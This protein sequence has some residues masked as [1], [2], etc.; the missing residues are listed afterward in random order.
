MAWL[1]VN[2]DQLGSMW[3]LAGSGWIKPRMIQSKVNIRWF[4]LTM[5]RANMAQG[6][7]KLARLSFNL[8]KLDSDSIQHRPRLTRPNLGLG[9]LNSLRLVWTW[10]N[11]DLGWLGPTLSRLAQPNLDS[12]WFN[13]K[14][15][16]LIKA[17]ADLV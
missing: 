1:E 17:H 3:T 2:P 12:K 14:W 8:A 11:V 7:P 13:P 4:D 15:L 10:P 9:W 6:G 5:V 16:D